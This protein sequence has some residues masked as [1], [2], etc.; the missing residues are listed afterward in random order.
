[1]SATTLRPYQITPSPLLQ[2]GP[3]SL[4][5]LSD[6]VA[7][8]GTPC[9]LLVSDQGMAAAGW[10]ANVQASLARQNTV[11]LFLAPPGEPTVATV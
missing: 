3:E 10:V 1:M 11:A 8:L 4:S 2:V 6:Q 9:V 5:T 7:R